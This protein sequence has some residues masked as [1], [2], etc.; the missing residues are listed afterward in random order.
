MLHLPADRASA[1]TAVLPDLCHLH[2]R[3]RCDCPQGLA[4]RHGSGKPAAQA[5]LFPA[6]GTSD[7][8]LTGC[9]CS[10]ARVREK[11][12]IVCGLF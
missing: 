9:M 8:A 7:C 1:F 3:P 11:L 4:D 12:Y 5:G 6:P 2:L 10:L